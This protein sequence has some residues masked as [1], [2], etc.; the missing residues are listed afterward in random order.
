MTATFQLNSASP[1]QLPLAQFYF[2]VYI[3]PPINS[4]W[5][6]QN[7]DSPEDY[8]IVYLSDGQRKATV[9]FPKLKGF[10]ANFPVL[11][12]DN[13]LSFV[14]LPIDENLT[15]LNISIL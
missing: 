4:N 8:P 2:T 11:L 15:H 12:E 10:R 14:I 9:A 13:Q 1:V 6:V 3:D 7:I 5:F